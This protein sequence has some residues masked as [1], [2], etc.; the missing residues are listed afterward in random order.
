MTIDVTLDKRNLKFVA[1]FKADA[2]LAKAWSLEKYVAMRRV[3]EGIDPIQPGW[4]NGP[5]Q[6]PDPAA[7]IKLAA[8]ERNRDFIREFKAEPAYA[9]S[10]TLGEYV[11]MRR[12]D[13][14]IDQLQPGSMVEPSQA[15]DVTAPAEDF[16]AGLND[17]G[18]DPLSYTEAP[19]PQA[20]RE[21]MAQ[22]SFVR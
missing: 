5:K 17:D 16:G 18:R 11:A 12:V 4:P 14:G 7:E 8:D 19:L 13:V 6:T 9:K 21:A 22:T 15:G 10:M 20:V 1:E 2:G 3:D